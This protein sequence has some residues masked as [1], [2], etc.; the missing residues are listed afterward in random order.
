LPDGGRQSNLVRVAEVAF[1]E[2]L[3]DIHSTIKVNSRGGNFAPCNSLSPLDSVNIPRQKRQKA[4]MHGSSR[5][6]RNFARKQHESQPRNSPALARRSHGEMAGHRPVP[7]CRPPSSHVE[8]AEELPSPR[9]P[10]PR[11]RDCPRIHGNLELPQPPARPNT[12]QTPATGQQLPASGKQ[13]SGSSRVLHGRQQL[14]TVS[15]NRKP[16]RA[17]ATSRSPASSLDAGR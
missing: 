6:P 5:S 10:L 13:P 16:P 4:R 11:D 17:T 3:S 1:Q 12:I 9:A 14:R 8:G 2:H 15:G 7:A